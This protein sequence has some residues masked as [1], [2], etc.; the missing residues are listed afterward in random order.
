[1]PIY[2]CDEGLDYLYSIWIYLYPP[3]T[4]YNTQSHGIETIEFLEPKVFY[5]KGGEG[6]IT[7]SDTMWYCDFQAIIP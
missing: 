4:V 3:W 2:F 6:F 7:C 5:L 1:M